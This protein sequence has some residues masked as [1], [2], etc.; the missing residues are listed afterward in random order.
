MKNAYFPTDLLL[1]TIWAISSVFGL[2]VGLN[3]VIS[4]PNDNGDREGHYESRQPDHAP[5]SYFLDL[6]CM[7]LNPNASW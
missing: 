2:L 6:S 5:L 7:S 1:M 3:S 4:G